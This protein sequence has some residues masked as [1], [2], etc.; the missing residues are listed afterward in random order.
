[1]TQLFILA[2]I[3]FCLMSA[4]IEKHQIGQTTFLIVLSLFPFAGLL[5]AL[6]LLLIP[7]GQI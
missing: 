3:Q 5:A 2:A 6:T 7:K 1:M 4:A